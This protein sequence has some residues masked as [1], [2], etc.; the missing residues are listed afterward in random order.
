M[1]CFIDIWIPVEGLL[2][3]SSLPLIFSTIF[4]AAADT[5]NERFTKPQGHDVDVD[6]HVQIYQILLNKDMYYKE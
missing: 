5:D 3:V 1:R 4:Y 2:M 6:A